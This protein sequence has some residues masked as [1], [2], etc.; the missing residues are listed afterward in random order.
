[1]Y[2]AWVDLRDKVCFIFHKVQGCCMEKAVMKLICYFFVSQCIPEGDKLH[3]CIP[4][5]H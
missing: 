3:F 2:F 5:L 4:A 1:M